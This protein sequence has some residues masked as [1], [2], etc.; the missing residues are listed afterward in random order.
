MKFERLTLDLSRPPVHETKHFHCLTSEGGLLPADFLAELLAPKS[1]IEGLEPTAYNFAEGERIK[2]SIL[3]PR[4]PAASSAHA[5]F[6]C[7]V[8]IFLRP[9]SHMPLLSP[10]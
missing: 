8:A 3:A 9:E 1:A 4:P 7:P 2:G 10:G 5:D 6:R